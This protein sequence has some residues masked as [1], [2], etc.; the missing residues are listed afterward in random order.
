MDN[1][2]RRILGVDGPEEL[3]IRG[4]GGMWNELGG[5]W[6]Q[7]APG[8]GSYFLAGRKNREQYPNLTINLTIT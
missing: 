2:R 6:L 8:I 5:M 1:G 4:G 7:V 3:G